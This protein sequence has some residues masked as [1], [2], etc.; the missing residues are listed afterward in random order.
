M[1]SL[2]AVYPWFSSKLSLALS[3]TLIGAP[4]GGFMWPPFITWL[5]HMY[6]LRGVLVVMAGLH[7]Q[8]LV[9]IALLRPG[10]N[11]IFECCEQSL[12]EMTSQTATGMDCT[13]SGVFTGPEDGNMEPG[14]IQCNQLDV[15]SG[16]KEGFMKPAGPDTARKV[17]AHNGG[18]RFKDLFLWIFFLAITLCYTGYIAPGYITVRGILLGHS[19]TRSAFLSSIMGIGNGI[20]RFSAG[21][22]GKYTRMR[23]KMAI[24]VAAIAMVGLSSILSILCD[25]YWYLAC[26]SALWGISTGKCFIPIVLCHI[27]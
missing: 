22:L 3:F 18:W 15:K 6:S 25:A 14:G 12:T 7:I 13:K 8:G 5:L 24:C 2:A 11:K 16:P 23:P 1:V 9:F 27:L 26:Y 20:G 4:I 19:D 10:E 17:A 21:L